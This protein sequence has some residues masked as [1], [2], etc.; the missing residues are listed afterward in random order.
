MNRDDLELLARSLRHATSSSTGPDLDR[1]LADLGWRDALAHDRRAAISTLFE[2]QGEHHATSS[3]LGLVLADA[4]GADPGPDAGILLPVVS[5]A[6]P[7]GRLD[8]RGLGVD[9]L[10]PTAATTMAVGLIV[11]NGDDGTIVATVPASSLSFTSI[12]G[13]DPD[14]GLVRVTG[15]DVPMSTRTALPDGA[16]ASAVALARLALAHELVGASRTMLELARQH[17]LE[18]VQF[19]RPIS[20]FQAVRHRL[21]EALVA[22][23]VAAASVDAAWLD[24][25]PAAASMAKA[26]AGRSARTVARHSQQVL[27][28]IGFTT[29]HD[30]HHSLRRTFLLNALF[31]TAASLTTALGHDLLASKRLPPLLPL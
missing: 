28:G 21:A 11:A 6:D 27:A 2:L 20:S 3:A 31:G 10:A 18:R 24:G 17:A 25:S 9:A 30:F 26:T 13:L 19:D 23:E 15:A 8:G 4:L 5:R 16:W 1:A 7:P 14:A 29:E 12:D 22:I